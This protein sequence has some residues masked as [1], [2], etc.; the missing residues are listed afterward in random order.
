MLGGVT[1]REPN[2]RM[3]ARTA[4][5]VLQSRSVDLADVFDASAIIEPAAARVVA[6]S[7]AHVRAA[8]ELRSIIADE[9]RAISDIPAFT[10]AQIRFHEEIVIL[11][12]NSTLTLVM[13]MLNEVIDRAV[14]HV[15]SR[16]RPEVSARRSSIRSHEQLAELIEGGDGDSAQA[17]WSSH[18]ARLRKALLGERGSS[19]V[20]LAHHL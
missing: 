10:N 2:R 14:A 19:V 8:K 12:G 4:A 20:D 3:T 7:R 5:L 18:M 13:E 9:K 1:V 17:H 6:E 15:L 11:S 16:P